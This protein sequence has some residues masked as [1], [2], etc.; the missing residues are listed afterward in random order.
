MNKDYGYGN[1]PND[2]QM[3]LDGEVDKDEELIWQGQ[4]NPKRFLL[5][6]IPIVIFG[7]IWT[8]ML[9][10]MLTMALGFGNGGPGMLILLFLIPFFLVGAGMLSSPY[11][12]M[13]A[14]KKTIY[15]VTDKRAIII[16]KGW[17]TRIQSVRPEKLV[18]ISKRIR[19][20]GSGDL[21]F[22]QCTV[23]SRDSSGDLRVSNVGFYGVEQVNEVED[24]LEK[25]HEG[26]KE[27]VE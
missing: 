22:S 7:V 24:I 11:W 4:P 8:G 1:T 2:L 15:A 3:I 14:S 18:N 19:G 23:Y 20:D 6:T 9:I 26:P 16:K 25:L 5:F 13:R 17:S 27:D 12:A 10:F 21:I